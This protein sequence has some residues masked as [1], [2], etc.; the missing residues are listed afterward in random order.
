MTN[1]KLPSQE[2]IIEHEGHVLVLSWTRGNAHGPHI[3]IRSQEYP[4][5]NPQYVGMRGHKFE[6]KYYDSEQNNHVVSLHQ[7][8]LTAL[9]AAY[10]MM[11]TRCDEA[12]QDVAAQKARGKAREQGIAA[13]DHYFMHLSTPTHPTHPGEL[14]E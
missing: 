8:H 5:L 3:S 1:T 10:D 13:L 14:P 6:T 7:H 2:R 4:G 9:S 12:A 11:A